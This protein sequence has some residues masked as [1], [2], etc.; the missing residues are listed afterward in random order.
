MIINVE[1]DLIEA[2]PGHFGGKPCLKGH[3]FTVAQI[4][5]ELADGQNV[6]GLAA[7]FDLEAK[8]LIQVL[9][10]IAQAFDR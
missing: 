2:K 8:E 1:S 4:L 3:R 6:Y 7:E 9:N 5:A 10:D